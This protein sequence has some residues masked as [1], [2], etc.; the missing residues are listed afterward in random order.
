MRDAVLAER[1]RTELGR[2]V[3]HPGAII[4]TATQGRVTLSGAVPAPWM[5]M[6]KRRE[7]LCFSIRARCRLSSCALSSRLM[8]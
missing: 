6:P 7:I 8:R 5:S 4:V 2:L 3:S 1:V